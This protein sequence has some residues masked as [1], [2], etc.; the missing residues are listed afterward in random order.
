[1][2]SMK[3]HQWRHNFTEACAIRRTCRRRPIGRK[4]RTEAT[5]TSQHSRLHRLHR[6]LPLHCTAQHRPSVR[7]SAGPPAA[8]RRA[9]V[10]VSRLV[11]QS[12]GRSVGG[13]VGQSATCSLRSWSPP[14][15]HLADDDIGID[16][17]DRDRG[18][19]RWFGSASPSLSAIR[20]PAPTYLVQFRQENHLPR[21]KNVSAR[22]SEWSVMSP[23]C[24]RA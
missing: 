9:A 6:L 16:P 19:P 13:S 4:E 22:A 11:S 23:Q 10:I 3:T 5:A 24:G 17:R 8:A 14:S 1:M 2:R 18:G 7:L 15:W 12:V 21:Q 20:I